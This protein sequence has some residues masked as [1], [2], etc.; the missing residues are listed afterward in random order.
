MKRVVDAEAAR[1]EK[2]NARLRAERQA[3][4]EA[5]QKVMLASVAALT[6]PPTHRLVGAVWRVC[7]DE[8]L[9]IQRQQRSQLEAKV[10]ELEDAYFSGGV[11]ALQS[12]LSSIGS[13]GY[14][15]R[16]RACVVLGWWDHGTA[17]V[18][19][20]HLLS[21]LVPCVHHRARQGQA[22]VG[23][24]VVPGCAALRPARQGESSSCC[25]AA[26][27]PG[28]SLLLWR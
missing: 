25:Q 6:T 27:R 2:E 1:A 18:N 21:V 9:F 16:V 7:D 4:L 14:T 22:A 15:Q 5:Q 26:G 19:S 3:R 13:T 12:T 11:K 8:Q 20:S 23:V 17:D 28:Q 24:A 10:Q